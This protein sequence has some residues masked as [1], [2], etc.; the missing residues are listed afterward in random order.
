M[1]YHVVFA[2]QAVKKL[3][4]MDRHT[5][6]LITGWVRKN[7]EGCAD[8]RR[9]GKGL[10]ANRSGQWRYRVGDY[11]LLAEINEEEVIILILTVGHRRDVYEK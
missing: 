10:T 11:R 7:L 2:D 6:L 9:F 5:A 3:K 8:P 1:S 4:K